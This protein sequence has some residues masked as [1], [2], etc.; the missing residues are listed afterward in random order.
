MNLMVGRLEIVVNAVLKMTMSLSVVSCLE[1]EV[2]EHLGLIAFLL[3]KYHNIM[4][5]L[6]L[7]IDLSKYEI[8]F[9]R[10]TFK[11]F[12]FGN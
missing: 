6:F 7:L 3:L 11:I 2:L 10:K 4:C 1:V 8:E 9:E 5:D 12:T